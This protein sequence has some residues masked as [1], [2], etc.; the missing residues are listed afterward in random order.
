MVLHYPNLEMNTNNNIPLD[1]EALSSS[2]PRLAS[3]KHA[4][5]L[6]ANDDYFNRFNQKLQNNIEEFEEI[7]QEAP[8]LASIPKYNPFE[9]P[10]HYFDDLPSRV[11]QIVS[12][13]KSST[14]LIEWLMLVIQPRFVLPVIITLFVS[15]SGIRYLNTISTM[16]KMEASEEQSTE[17]ELWSID[18]GTIMESMN[19]SESTENSAVASDDASIQ[20]YLIENNVD[21]ANL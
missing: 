17:E 3:I 12:T 16:P 4:S 14:S 15:F 11:Q 21:E 18:E 2:A 10:T 20:N 13:K 6:V 1:E 5:P 8:L 9:V 7:K 19:A